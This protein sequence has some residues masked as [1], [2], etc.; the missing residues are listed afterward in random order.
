MAGDLEQQIESLL[1]DPAHQDHPLLAV[2]QKLLAD[3]SKLHRRL[4]RIGRISDGYQSQLRELNRE[5]VATN[6]RLGTALSEV[7]TLRGFVPICSRCKKIRDDE[8]FW[9]EVENYLARHSEAVL[10][11]GVCPECSRGDDP[12]SRFKSAE[13]ERDEQRRV[14]DVSL[15]YPDNP[16]L[17]EHVQLSKRYT[18]LARRLDKISKISDGFQTQLKDLNAVLQRD[19]LTDPLTGL[20]NRRAM[21]DRLRAEANRSERGGHTFTVMMCDLDHFKRVNDTYGHE[22]GDQVLKEVAGIFRENLRSFD[23]CARWGGEEF[24]VLLADTDSENAMAVAE[25]LRAL[26]QEQP[27][28]YAGHSISIT[29]SGGLATHDPENSLTETLREADRALY[30]A[31]SG[32]NRLVQAETL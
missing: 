28:P 11:H 12:V 29:V 21:L 5:L 18:K 32:R 25:K 10:S 7:R 20:A 31:K 2:C 23:L 30:A 27:V 13:E 22:A 26:V 17:S 6:D 14:E 24:L 9:D 16:L 3:R 8:G 4:E 15:R 1:A 19:S